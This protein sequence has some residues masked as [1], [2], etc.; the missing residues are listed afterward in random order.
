MRSFTPSL[1]ALLCAGALFS[2]WDSVRAADIAKPA[3]LEIVLVSPGMVT[4]STVAA[5]KR[6]GF[7]GV[8]IAL[9]EEAGKVALNAAA[10]AAAAGQLGVYFWMEVARNPALANA[11]PRWMASLGMHDDWQKRFPGSRLPEKD[12]V[13]KAWP[14]VPIWYREAFDA[15]L[16]RI[17]GLLQ[18][19]PTN[20][21]G[22]LLNDLQGAPSSCGCGNLQCRWATDYRVPATGARIEG[23]GAPA[24]FVAGIKKLTGN[25]LVIPIWTTECEDDDLPASRRKGRASTGLCGT[26]GCSVGLCP[27]EF[28]RQW[29]ALI[30]EHSGPVGVLALHREF[31]RAGDLYGND[32][33]W[34]SNAVA[35]FDQTPPA[36]GGEALAHDRLWLV[37]E[38]GHND[39]A[40]ARRRA[41]E[42]G[43]SAILVTRTRIDQSY[44]PRIIS[45]K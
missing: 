22:L 6:E 8:A 12:E 34:L 21:L 44:K 38:G 18:R 23:E 1:L 43:A 24:K 11:H 40:S 20:Y 3:P 30:R 25:K 41:K 45:A 29:S 28:T 7:H 27:T 37:V 31:G 35:Y 19:A 10:R 9:D 36:H 33:A 15:Q 39:E 14:W 4:P 26:V 32:A 2:G 16:K 5:W 17:D 42:L 13:A